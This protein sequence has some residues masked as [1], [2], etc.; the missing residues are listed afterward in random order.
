MYHQQAWTSKE[1]LGR[2]NV[3]EGGGVKVASVVAADVERRCLGIDGWD[4]QQ[5]LTALCPVSQQ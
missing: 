1:M 2:R 5:M 4:A 3:R